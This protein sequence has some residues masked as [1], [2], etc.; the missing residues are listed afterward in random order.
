[1]EN[2]SHAREKW[3]GFSRTRV[4]SRFFL[5]V[6]DELLCDALLP[7]ATVEAMRLGSYHGFW[8]TESV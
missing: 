3:L 8:R 2:G 5:A 7:K 4:T 6:D 1:M